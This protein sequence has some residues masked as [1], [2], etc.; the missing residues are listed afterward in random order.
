MYEA[1]KIKSSKPIPKISSI[2]KNPKIFQKPQNLGFQTWNACKWEKRNLPNEEKTLKKLEKNLESGLE[3]KRVFWEV[4]G[5][6]CRE[7]DR[8]K[9]EENRAKPLYRRSVKLYK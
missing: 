5:W 8:E 9:W 4:K 6:I 2:L 7:R 3:L 1:F